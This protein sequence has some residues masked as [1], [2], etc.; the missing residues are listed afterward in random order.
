MTRA[1][2]L[3]FATALHLSAATVKVQIGKRVAELPLEKYVAAVLAGEAGV[4][5]SDEALKA[6]AVVAR[7]YAIRMRGRHAAEGFDLCATTHCQRL[8][9]DSVTPR[10]QK[11]ADTTAGEMLWY[12][13]KLAFTPYSLD[14]GGRTESAGAVWPDEREPYLASHADEYCVR[15]GSSAWQWAGDPAAIAAALRKQGL[16]SPPHITQIRVTQRSDSG[17]AQ[18][19]DLLGD[20]AAR[21]AAGAF[22]FAIGRELGWN[23]L[24]SDWFDAHE[25]NGKLIFTGRGSG[26]SVGLWPSARRGP[27]GRRGPRLSWYLLLPWNRSGAASARGFRL[28][29][30]HR[31]GSR[32]TRLALRGIP[33]C[34]PPPNAPC[35]PIRN[36]RDGR[37]TVQ[38]KCAS[39]P[40][41]QAQTP[42]AST[43]WV[44]AYARLA[45]RDATRT[46]CGGHLAPRVVSPADRIAGRPWTAPLVS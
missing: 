28:A 9:L 12:R 33:R 18:L 19:L 36:V 15:A 27:D 42:P 10:L 35:A 13:G 25:A 16:H 8:D 44:A 45:H 37:R 40:M 26:H 23:S 39:T 32:S 29:A 34:S 2:I 17:R 11:L 14:C 24:R 30:P 43:G 20:P 7:T 38:S 3:V 22:R 46:R 41:L 21:I 1:A 4:F 5:R 6:M 31:A